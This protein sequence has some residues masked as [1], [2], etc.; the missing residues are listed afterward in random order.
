VTAATARST[1]FTAA[2]G[3]T[4]R[5]DKSSAGMSAEAADSTQASVGA[6]GTST[7]TP[8]TNT[9]PWTAITIALR[10]NSAAGLSVSTSSASASFSANL[11][12][13]DATSTYTVTPTVLD[14]R[15]GASAGL[16]WQLQVTSTTLTTG[17]RSLATTASSITDVAGDACVSGAPC[18]LPTSNVSYPVAVPAAA[19]APTAVKFDNAAV[20]TG[21]GQISKSTAFSVSV[22]QNAYAGTYTSTV[23]ISIVSGP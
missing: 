4:E 12:A 1:S 3:D 6:S 11:N 20:Q 5:F 13:G 7:V 18:V 8:A 9:S 16:G 17:A 22:P 10:D 19:S 14:T 21:E 23:T 2:A 15:S